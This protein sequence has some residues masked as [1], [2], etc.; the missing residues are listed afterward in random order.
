M[1]LR[2][3]LGLI[4]TVLF[5]IILF[6]IILLP[7]FLILIVLLIWSIYSDLVPTKKQNEIREKIDNWIVN[8][9]K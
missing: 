2:R 4:F 5:V 9:W 3:I 7:L 8:F 1:D 6:Y